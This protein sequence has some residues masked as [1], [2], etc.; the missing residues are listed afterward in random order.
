MLLK[1]INIIFFEIFDRN[2]R[3]TL[4]NQNINKMKLFLKYATS[5]KCI[6]RSLN[7]SIFVGTIL[8][9]I[10]HFDAIIH[11]KFSAIILYQIA[12]T[13][14]VPYAVSTYSTVMETKQNHL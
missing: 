12:L 13:Y 11:F 5:K 1:F 2:L 14:F 3:L 7:V 8:A 6:Q 4:L 9:L 10:N